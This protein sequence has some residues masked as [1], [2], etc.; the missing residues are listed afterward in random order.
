[1]YVLILPK[2]SLASTAEGYALQNTVLVPLWYFR[3]A[4]A[5]SYYWFFWL[6]IC[7][8]LSDRSLVRGLNWHVWEVD[9]AGGQNAE[10]CP[11]QHPAMENGKQEAGTCPVD[12]SAMGN[13]KQEADK[14]PVDHSAL[15]AIPGGLRNGKPAKA[16]CPFGFGS[17]EAGGPTMT[18]LHCPR[19]A[20]YP[21][22]SAMLV[23]PHM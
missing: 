9:R 3:P 23:N 4:A 17:K 16:V 21:H 18:S 11:V 22:K 15:S 10:R 20:F 5:M 12:H 8:L 7:W 13:G 1:M 19:Y 6:Y 14:C 2:T